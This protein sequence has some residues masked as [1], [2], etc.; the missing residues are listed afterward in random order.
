[1]VLADDVRVR[2]G[3]EKK[4]STRL[5]NSPF[6]GMNQ[7]KAVLRERLPERSQ[8]EIKRTS[9]HVKESK[10]DREER[11]LFKALK[12]QET[13]A[14]IPYERRNAIKSRL[15]NIN[16]FDQF[17]LL[18]AVRE[19]IGSTALAGLTELTPTSIQRLSITELTKGPRP[20][21]K[22]EELDGDDLLTPK[23][24]HYLMAAETGSGKTLG[25]LIPVLDA[26]KRAELAEKENAPDEAAKRQE[27]KKA[28]E[29][30]PNRNI[31]ELESPEL[32]TP[33]TSNVA[34]PKAIVLVP[35]SELVNQVGGVIK[36]FSHVVKVRA[37]LLHSSLTPRR[38]RNSLFAP[39]GL[40][41]IVTTPHLI[42][43]IAES[44]P[45]IFSRVT[46]LVVDE[47]D[48]LLD[49]SFSPATSKVIDRTAPTL[50]K[51]VFC[52][53]TIPK[54]LDNY[55]NRFFPDT[56][57]LVTPNLHSIPR[58]VQLGVVDIDKAPYR[59]NR[60]MACAD[61]IWSL[62]KS[63]VTSEEDPS[64]QLTGVKPPK[65][66]IV[67]VNERETAEEVA[68][69][70]VTKGVDAVALTRDTADKRK[71]EVLA[72][73]TIPKPLPSAE[74][75]KTLKKDKFR[76]DTIPFEG[77]DAAKEDPEDSVRRL[78]NTKVLVVTDLGSRGIDTV[79]VKTV[80]LYDVPHTSI[81]FIHR[82]GRV[83][84]MNRRGRGVVLVG[85]KDRKDIVREV[86]DAMFRGQALI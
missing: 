46:H 6:G 16:S 13:L 40:D 32:N 17:K 57:R 14:S 51:L 55:L 31:F 52:S 85:K 74:D 84:R 25:Y 64:Y 1:M 62:G 61:A 59:G 22:S 69:Y 67:F 66:I 60:S 41:I 37:A 35:T 47:A 7:T 75:V 10:G 21:V 24:D 73:F 48:S 71:E 9:R 63:G 44:N 82:L 27:E 38:I 5:P 26:I 78:G 2:Y 30:D 68:A 72:E 53:A 80:I 28:K 65:N 56:M 33:Q 70:L 36:Q 77:L 42:A 20:Q 86:R 11:P 18:P 34:R 49:K 76:S 8:A 12:M 23:F 43:S 45:Y 54:S 4:P 15:G 50:K 19:A 79:S 3:S 58:R 81:D 39:A 29:E 83:G